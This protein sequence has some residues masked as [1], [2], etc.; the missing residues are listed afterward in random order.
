M[1]QSVSADL[2]S[3]P[4]HAEASDALAMA[5]AESAAWPKATLD[6]LAPDGTH[7]VENADELR[8]VLAM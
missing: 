8:E 6:F 2:Q 5:L 1:D 3:P 7:M 4:E